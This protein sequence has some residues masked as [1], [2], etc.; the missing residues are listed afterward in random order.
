MINADIKY[1]V[2]ALSYLVT[3]L[4]IPAAI[5]MFMLKKQSEWI[6]GENE[7]HTCAYDCNVSYITLFTE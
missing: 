4:G 1:I 6:I 5:F 7:S 3:L 2:E